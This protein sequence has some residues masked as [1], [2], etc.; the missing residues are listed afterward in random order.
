MLIVAV[1][2]TIAWLRYN[3]HSQRELRRR[4][5]EADLSR[6]LAMQVPDRRIEGKHPPEA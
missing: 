3:S 6:A 2:S 4:R 5:M 1:A